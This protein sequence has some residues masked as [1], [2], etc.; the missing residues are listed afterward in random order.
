MLERRDPLRYNDLD[1]SPVT[2][3]RR[4]SRVRVKLQPVLCSCSGSISYAARR[5]NKGLRWLRLRDNSASRWRTFAD[6]ERT[7]CDHGAI[8]NPHGAPGVIAA[9]KAP[10]K[11]A[12]SGQS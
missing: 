5:D 3:P 1:Q 6:N 7:F 12:T 9:E 2:R 8:T 10:E 11:L 4:N